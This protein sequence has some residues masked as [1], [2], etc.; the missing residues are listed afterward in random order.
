MFS[1]PQCLV[2]I[3]TTLI[4]RA[5]ILRFPLGERIVEIAEGITEFLDQVRRRSSP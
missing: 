4:E 5:A 1:F 2:S 3:V